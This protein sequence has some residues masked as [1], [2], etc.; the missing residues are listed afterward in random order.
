M[1]GKTLGKK[2]ALC[3][4][5]LLGS[6][7]TAQAVPAYWDDWY[8]ADSLFGDKINEQY[9]YIHDI[10]DG[11]SG[12]NPLTD[13][14]TGAQLH[15]WLSDDAI[16]GDLP[17]FLGGDGPETVG[18]QFDGQNWNQ[19][20]AVDTVLFL[21][22]EFDFILTSLLQDGVLNV[23]ITALSGD[24]TFAASYLEAWGSDSTSVPA[25]ATLSLLGLGLM[26]LGF[27]ARRRRG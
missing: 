6:I 5:L 9:E 3:A 17:V 25:P 1:F 20:Y 11:A 4:A 23:T 14:L 27:A 19:T 8:H 15:I 26:C 21:P 10:R 7:G 22:Q 24:F 16:G 18:F 13:T 12:Y 2:A